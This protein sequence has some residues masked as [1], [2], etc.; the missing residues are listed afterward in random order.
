[1]FNTMMGISVND[2]FHT[3]KTIES[4]VSEYKEKANAKQKQI[5]CYNLMWQQ[6]W[7]WFFVCLFFF[8]Y[9]RIMKDL[10]LNRNE[11]RFVIKI[12][13]CYKFISRIYMLW[14]E[15]HV[16]LPFLTF[17]MESKQK[18]KQKKSLWILLLLKHRLPYMLKSLPRFS[19]LT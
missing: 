16:S 5:L 11:L 12:S 1:M 13:N 9:R 8:R 15:T 18:Q 6:F 19:F 3:H 14:N 10:S 4:Q 17:C 2:N 7:F